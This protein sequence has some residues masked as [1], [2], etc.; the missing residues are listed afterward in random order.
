M[1]VELC[2]ACFRHESQVRVPVFPWSGC[3]SLAGILCFGGS[4]ASVRGSPGLGPT[5]PALCML[6]F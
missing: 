2:A 3:P 5:W 1:A 6:G 4:S